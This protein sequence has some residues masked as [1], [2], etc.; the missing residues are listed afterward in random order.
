MI[1]PQFF[2]KQESP[3]SAAGWISVRGDESILLAIPEL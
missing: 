3:L 1:P 2:K